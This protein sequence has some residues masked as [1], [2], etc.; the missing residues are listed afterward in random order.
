M[1]LQQARDRAKLRRILTDNAIRLATQ[2]HW[3]EA[4]QTNRELLELV[5]RDVDLYNRLGKALM[6]LGRYRDA[7]DAYAESVKIDP[8][9]SIAKKNLARLETL[10]ETLPEEGEAAREKVDPRIFIEEIGKTGQASLTSLAGPATLARLTTGDQVYFQIDTRSLK[11]VN[12]RGEEIG[13]VEPRLAFRLIALMNGGNE[14]AAAI[15]SLGEGRVNIIIKELVQHPSQAGK[16]SFPA[17]AGDGF[18]GYI[19]G[20]V[21][22][23]HRGLDGGLVEDSEDGS[24]WP[25]DEDDSEGA[26]DE[27]HPYEGDGAVDDDDDD[28]DEEEDEV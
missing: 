9:N 13:E 17:R 10:A 19:K 6:E 28:D 5:P 26:T 4:I 23:R 2:G 12:N 22:D 20:S 1:S 25:R 24:G 15:T 8:N 3:E 16:V 18:R 21:I 27:L 11:V 14:Y 7:R